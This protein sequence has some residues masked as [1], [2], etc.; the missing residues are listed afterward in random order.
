M[1]YTYIYID[2]SNLVYAI[3]RNPKKF[4]ELS[5]F[6]LARGLTEIKKVQ[7]AKEQRKKQSK[8]IPSTGDG[9]STDSTTAAADSRGDQRDEITRQSLFS[10]NNNNNN[11]NNFNSN[12]NS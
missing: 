9:K 4:E 5:Q 7:L 11:N 1:L 10:S 8:N 6:T 12:S 3:V 2:N